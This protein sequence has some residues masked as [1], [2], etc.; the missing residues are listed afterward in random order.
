V[1]GKPASH[2]AA[3]ARSSLCFFSVRFSMNEI[4]P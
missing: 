2:A 1:I 3:K 4:L